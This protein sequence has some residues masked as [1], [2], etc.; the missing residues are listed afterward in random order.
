M[1]NGFH[2]SESE[3]WER[4]EGPLRRL[5]ATL[6]AFAATHGMTVRRNYHNW[7]HRSLR[8]ADELERAIE[9]GLVNER[10]PVYDVSGVAWAGQGP[11]RTWRNER[12]REAQPVEML[13]AGLDELLAHV[14]ELV[15][16]WTLG[17]LEPTAG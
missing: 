8:W 6:D 13:E 14:R 17:D 5:D 12:V 1:P 9:I 2:A 4:L 16:G 15:S 3:A 11:E 10:A 7:P